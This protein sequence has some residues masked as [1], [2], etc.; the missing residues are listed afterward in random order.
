MA[1]VRGQKAHSGSEGAAPP[2]PPPYHAIFKK[3]PEFLNRPL[4]KPQNV[5]NTSTARAQAAVA[6]AAAAAAPIE[7]GGSGAA[8]GSREGGS[9]AFYSAAGVRVH[10]LPRESR[11]HAIYGEDENHDAAATT[12]APAPGGEHP[13]QSFPPIV[14]PGVRPYRE[15]VGGSGGATEP[16]EEEVFP[17]FESAEWAEWVVSVEAMG[18]QWKCTHCELATSYGTPSRTDKCE[19][20]GT[21]TK[22]KAMAKPPVMERLGGAAGDNKYRPKPGRP[23]R[24]SQVEKAGELQAANQEASDARNAALQKELQKATAESNAANAGLFAG[25]MHAMAAAVNRLADA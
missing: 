13:R 7:E 21:R 24:D 25:A 12:Q 17:D 3:F 10:R 4:Q 9:A 5:R 18:G 22:G 1:E 2:S 23:S 15:R 8:E 20:C 6:Q 14:V 16:E 11:A 19:Q